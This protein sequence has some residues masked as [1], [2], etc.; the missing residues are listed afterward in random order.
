[1]KIEYTLKQV[2]PNIIAVIVPNHYDRAMLFCRAQEFYESNS[3]EFR[4]NDFDIWDYMRW[5]SSNNNGVFTYT[6]DWD[7]FN[8]PF[9]TLLNCYMNVKSD[10]PY[11]KTMEEIIDTILDMDN[12]ELINAYVIGTKS[13]KGQLFN[14]EICHALYFTNEEYKKIADE[15]TMSLPSYIR[16]MFKLNLTNLG[17]HAS[18]INDEIQACMVTNCKSKYFTNGLEMDELKPIYKDYKIRLN[19]FLKK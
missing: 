8:I 1:M 13:E 3:D 18:V 7:G 9:K 17:Y 11:D 16:L 12:I 14:H 2:K 5:Y 4:C 15:I 19:K 10:S 6:S